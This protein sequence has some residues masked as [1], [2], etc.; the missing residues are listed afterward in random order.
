VLIFQGSDARHSRNRH[1]TWKPLILL[2]LCENM[3]IARTILVLLI[4]L[5]VA[6]PAAGGAGLASKSADSIEMSA[7]EDMDCCPHKAN[8]CDRMGACTSM[9]ACAPHCF[10]FAVNGAPLPFVGL[11]LA[12]KMPVL[13]DGNVPS[14]SGIPPF[15]PPRV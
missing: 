2:F 11:T 3:S 15:R 9:A 13:Q 4:A 1:L 8:P 7:M 10:T 6:L 14:Q 12:D 5:S